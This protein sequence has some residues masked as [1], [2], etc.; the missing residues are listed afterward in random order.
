[1]AVS[2]EIY[3]SYVNEYKIVTGIMDKMES[4]LKTS[5]YKTLT[6]VAEDQYD[7][8]DLPKGSRIAVLT[9][10]GTYLA[11]SDA[12][13]S[14]DPINYGHGKDDL[15]FPVGEHLLRVTADKP[16][17]YFNSGLTM[18]GKKT[19]ANVYV[20]RTKDGMFI[21]G[22]AVAVSSPVTVCQSSQEVNDIIYSRK[23][24]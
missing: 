8:H 21:K 23:I 11:R 19:Q 17:G 13:Q 20:Q 15:G 16:T 18:D 22:I 1:M 14:H 12:R 6:K 7:L 5:D 10:T 3:E 4:D 9:V 2:K 24:N